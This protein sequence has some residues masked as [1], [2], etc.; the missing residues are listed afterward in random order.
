VRLVRLLKEAFLQS[1]VAGNLLE[2]VSRFPDKPAV[3]DG[4]RVL[5]F[6]QLAGA[7]LRCA[8]FL[9]ARAEAGN[10]AILLPS[11]D[12]FAITF[13]GIMLSGRVPVPLN[14][15]LTPEEL[16]AVIADCGARTVL[17]TRF[18]AETA[19]ALPVAAVFVEDLV[20]ALASIEPAAPAPPARLAT[21]LYTSGTTGVPKGVM[22]S[23]R[24]LLANIEGCVEH[25]GF[26]PEDVLL[27]MLPLFHSFGL[28][29][30]L[31]LPACI[32]ATTVLI[33]RF[34]PAGALAT[35]SRRRVT[36]VLAVPSM[37]RALIKALDQGGH[38]LLSLRLPISGGEP[39]GDEIPRLYA[40]RFGITIY[41][42]YGLTE[43]SPAVSAN[44]PRHS[45]PGTVGRPLPN[46]EVRIADERGGFAGV[47]VDGE[48]FVRGAAVMEGYFNRPAD[49]AAVISPDGF[50]STG[51]IG[52]L[53]ADGFLRIT[54]RKKE[55]IISAGENI[56]PREIEQVL[57]RHPAV[58]E[59]AVIGVPDRSRGEVPMAFVV[60]REGACAD[61]VELKDFC[62]AHIA[63]YK[64]PAEIEF[65]A[66]LPHSP[67]GKVLKRRLVS[68]AAGRGS[69]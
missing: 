68:A 52:R 27:G 31:T 58:A 22:L 38:D 40:E 53:D 56:F 46:V 3:I 43:T 55:M 54:G 25:L 21:I 47:D 35:M 45:R 19:A 4:D 15:F 39:L 62:R 16:T 18:F 9:N 42:G 17:T 57:A 6:R 34:E 5:S 61:A 26:G 11:C 65:R 60:L 66:D 10:V 28:A 44:T 67:S 14:F 64:V 49:T 69:A 1:S 36:A 23:H 32:G 30:A 12:A 51:D 59:A 37:Y 20:P 63:R 41:E 33:R 2:T 48:I 8:G 29:I 13:F 24:N 50:L 7:S